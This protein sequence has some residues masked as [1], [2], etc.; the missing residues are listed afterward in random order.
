M[1][2]LR[3]SLL[4][5]LKIA[6]L[7]VVITSFI[8]AVAATGEATDI[9]GWLAVLQMRIQLK[10]VLFVAAYI[11][12]WHLVLRRC[13]LYRSYR[14]SGISRELRDIGIAVA[15]ATLPLLPMTPLFRFNYVTVPFL[16][17]FGAMAF[18]GLSLERRILRAVGRYVRRY[19]RN[20]RNVLIV[21][22]G[23]ET[24]ELAARLARRDDLGYSVVAVVETGADGA[25]LSPEHCREVVAKVEAYIERRPIDEIFVGLPLDTSQPLVASLI[26]VCEQQGI[27]VRVL[28]HVAS[29]YW[30]RARIDE[31]EGQPVLTMYSGQPDS[32]ALLLKRVIDVCGAAIGLLVLAP[33]FGIVAIAIKLESS[34]PVFFAQRRVG[35]NRRRFRALKFRTM[36]DGAEQLQ[37]TLEPLNEADGPVFKIINDP[38]VTRVGRWLRRLSI[39]EL[40]QLINVVKGEMSLVGP[41]PLPVRDVSRIAVR[42]HKRR[43]SVKP[44]I[45]CLW[46]INSR[47][48]K[49][50]EWIRWD[51][52]YID[53]WSVGLDLK[54]LARTIPAVLSGQGAH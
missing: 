37:S 24:F 38:R 30:A 51:M 34:G 13:H 5:F 15:I 54:I 43:F 14:L 26:T 1:V 10:N 21:G 22:T 46:Q 41:R 47:Q 32:L 23:S 20:L 49:F 48:P 11:V 36:V 44:G 25:G 17:M 42:W 4:T 19:G 2:P 3:R 52:E 9:H 27:T 35:L 6:D 28:A 16:L 39:D 31:L 33:L 53:N 50:D 29:L 12:L 8:V 18:V 40:P 7:G 45:T